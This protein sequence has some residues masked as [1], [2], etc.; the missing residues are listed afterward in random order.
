MLVVKTIKIA[1]FN[2]SAM[3]GNT[4]ILH[5]TLY[6]GTIPVST[7]LACILCWCDRE[8]LGALWPVT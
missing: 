6:W 4:C 7:M 8:T 5:T 3:A 2:V 1:V